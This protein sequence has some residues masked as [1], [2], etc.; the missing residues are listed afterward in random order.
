MDPAIGRILAGRGASTDLIL[1]AL[2]EG[3]TII[4]RSRRI[5]FANKSAARMLATPARALIGRPYD[6]AFFGLDK[7]SSEAELAVCPIQFSLSEAAASHMND[8]VFVRSDGSDFLVEYVCTPIFDDKGSAGLVLSFRDVT[9]RREFESAVAGA[10]DAALE[11]ARTKAAFLANISHEIRTPLS[12][13]VGTANLLAETNLC[14]EQERYVEMLKQSIGSLLETVNDILDFSKIE[15]GKMRLN[16]VSFKIPDLVEE[17]VLLFRPVAEAK[18]LELTAEIGGELDQSF[19][20]DSGRLK[21]VLNNLISNAVKFTQTGR[22]T[23]RA[24]R[25]QKGDDVIRFEVADTGIGIGDS[26]RSCLFQPF[27]QADISS[28][29]R[30]GGTGLGLAISKELVEMMEGEIGVESAPGD[31]S[32]FWFTVRLAPLIGHDAE[33]LHVSES[34]GARLRV[35]LAEDHEISTAIIRKLLE[36]SGCKVHSARNGEEAVLIAGGHS[37][38]LILMDCQMPEI[39]GY[40]AARMI[41]SSAGPNAR[42]K[43]IALSANAEELERDKCIAAGM[44]DFLCKPLT[45]E[46]IAM[47]LEKHFA[48]SLAEPNLDLAPDLF[49]HSLAKN[50]TPEVLENLR[51]IESRGDEGFVAEIF[52]TYFEFTEGEVRKIESAVAERD[53]GTLK[54]R[55]HALKGSSANLGLES[56]SRLCSDVEASA[57]AYDAERIAAEKLKAEF[58]RIKKEILNNI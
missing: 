43:I 18:G 53:L 24:R 37:F 38:D 31:G 16:L 39:D 7:T 5:V 32:L 47:M 40:A 57:G 35:L 3:V 20:G 9:Q 52:K 23:V 17:T 56:M 15:A 29:R 13:I 12:G 14:P 41:R 4:D 34:P 6:L 46:N 26:E 25:M 21:Q 1:E 51:A 45:R 33:S 28:T 22:I 2:L 42:T 44:D 10:R 48:D 36:G 55:A 54:K 50:V 30:F 11:A 49:Q 58:D 27:T 8:G 19:R